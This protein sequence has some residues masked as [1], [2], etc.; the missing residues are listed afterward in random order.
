MRRWWQS[1]VDSCD[2]QEDLRPLA[3][4]RILVGVV[5]TLDLLRAWQLGLVPWIW[6]LFDHGGLSTAPQQGSYWFAAWPEAGT[7]L[8]VVTLVS[9]VGIALGVGVR[10]LI[11]VG[12]LAWAQLGHLHPLGD[13]GVDRLL[14]TTLLVLLFTDSHRR[15]A[16]G[17]AMRRRPPQLTHR[18]WAGRL[19]RWFLVIVYLSA[20]VA[21]ACDPAWFSLSDTPMLYRIMTDPTAADL[22]HL[23]W[24]GVLWPFRIGG[25][26]TVLLEL[27][28]PL[29]LTRYAKWW[30][31]AGAAM[32][33]GIAMTMGLGMFSWGM[34]AHYPILLAPFWLPWVKAFPSEKRAS[35]TT[36]P[37]PRQTAA[38]GPTPHGPN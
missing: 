16:L 23:Q 17:N 30:A 9:M 12:V 33:L 31:I 21:K 25:I 27:S 36:L 4:V 34:L 19:L 37:A 8:F 38:S 29:L 5:V 1:W 28:A 35:A 10:P 15:W 18:A 3:L 32:H 14:R 22:D 20:G 7:A 13:R 6:R 11:V 26:G 2:A 24:A